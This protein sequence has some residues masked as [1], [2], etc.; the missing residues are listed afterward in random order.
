MFPRG[1]TSDY[2]GVQMTVEECFASKTENFFPRGL[3]KLPE[4]WQ[5]IVTNKGHNILHYI[6]NETWKKMFVYSLKNDRA[7]P[8]T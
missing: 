4:R 2:K 8:C 5:T 3:D 1:D 7:F 6:L